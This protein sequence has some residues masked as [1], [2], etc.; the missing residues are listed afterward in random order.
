MTDPNILTTE[1]ATE[2]PVEPVEPVK[3]VKVQSPAKAVSELPGANEALPGTVVDPHPTTWV[4][5]RFRNTRGPVR[6][7][8][9]K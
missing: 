1:N 9:Q 5:E 8:A 6:P 3:P 2:G 4:Q 7:S